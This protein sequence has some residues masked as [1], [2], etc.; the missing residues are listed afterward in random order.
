MKLLEDWGGYDMTEKERLEKIKEVHLKRVA[1]N[2]LYSAR[3]LDVEWLIEQAEK[4]KRYQKA[5]ED[6]AE[7]NGILDI[8]DAVKLAKREL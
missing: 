4:V 2:E 1:E 8:Y 6:I 3:F 7:C 5:L